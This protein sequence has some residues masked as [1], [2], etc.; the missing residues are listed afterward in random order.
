LIRPNT[1]GDPV[2]LFGVPK[3]APEPEP[4]GDEEAALVALLAPDEPAA[5]DE[6]DELEDELEPQP[7]TAS[8]AAPA[9]AT[10]V[11]G[12]RSDLMP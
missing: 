1:Y 10:A 6:L 8:A 11:S 12:L 3:P 7:A 5:L 4:E 2:A 9:T